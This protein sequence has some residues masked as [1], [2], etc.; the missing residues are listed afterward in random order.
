MHWLNNYEIKTSLKQVIPNKYF[1]DWYS[2]VKPILLNHE[3]QVRRLFKHHHKSVWD[4]SIEVSFKAYYYATKFNADSRICAIGGLLH[5]FYPL[6]WQYSQELYDY[7]CNY[8]KRL[9][10]KEPLFKKHGFTHAYEA[11]EN[12]L[13]YFSE[14]EDVIISDVII[15]HMFPLNIKLPKYRE[16]WIVSCVDKVESTKDVFN[17]MMQFISSERGYL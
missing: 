16:S 8:L 4:Q 11:Y 9:D 7:D 17:I 2:I 12:Y 3:F 14:Y 13:K 6:A 1:N 10:M 15:K 5:D